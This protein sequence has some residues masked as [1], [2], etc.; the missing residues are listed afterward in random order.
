VFFFGSVA[1]LQQQGCRKSRRK[2]SASRGR[3]GSTVNMNMK[4]FDVKREI[5][6]NSSNCAA[7]HWLEKSRGEL[8]SLCH[9]QVAKLA[10]EKTRSD[11]SMVRGDLSCR[12][13]C[14]LMYLMES[15]P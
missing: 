1:A 3:L 9:S 5:T 8:P 13:L 12:A 2:Q 15:M 14:W 6:L 11:K 4:V 7:Q 10:Y